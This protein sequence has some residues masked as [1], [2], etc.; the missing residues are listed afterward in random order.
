MVLL[1]V[2]RGDQVQFL[3][4]TALNRKTDEVIEDV[5]AIY[6]ARLKVGRICSGK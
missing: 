3:Y 5:A 6:N 2:K 4:E 1:T